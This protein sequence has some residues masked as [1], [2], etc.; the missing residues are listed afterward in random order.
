MAQAVG[1]SVSRQPL[2]ATARVRSQ[3]SPF[4]ICDAQRGTMTGFSPSTPVL[5]CQDH[6]TSAPYSFITNIM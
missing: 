2:T 5:P 1:R 4:E 3:D 6:S